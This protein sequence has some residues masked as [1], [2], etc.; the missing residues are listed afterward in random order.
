MKKLLWDFLNK[1]VWL[2]LVVLL[3]I[4][5]SFMEVKGQDCVGRGNTCY[6]KEGRHY[7][8][9]GATCYGINSELLCEYNEHIPFLNESV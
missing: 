7:C 1:K 9:E 4:S 6:F 8:A 2:F 5:A 3:G